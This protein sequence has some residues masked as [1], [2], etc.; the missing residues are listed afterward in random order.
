MSSCNPL[1]FLFASDRYKVRLQFAGQH[2]HLTVFSR[3]H[4]E[5]DTF[6]NCGTLC[7]DYEELRSHVATKLPPDQAACWDFRRDFE[8]HGS[9]L[10][11][12]RI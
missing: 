5:G 2:V 1:D 12:H 9:D 8:I 11:A 4:H 7:F 6:A 3:A 10:L